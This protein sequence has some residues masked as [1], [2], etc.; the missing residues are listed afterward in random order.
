[1]RR[2]LLSLC[3]FCIAAFSYAQ[4][5]ERLSSYEQGLFGEQLH[6]SSSYKVMSQIQQYWKNQYDRLKTDKYEIVQC[7]TGESVLKVT[8]PS[9]YLFVDNNS[10]LQ[11]QAD[12]MLRPF[13]RFLRGQEAV[14]TVIIACYSDDNGSQNYLDFMTLN[15]A[16]SVREWLQK[17]GVSS[18]V[19]CYGM[20][21]KVPLN[22]NRNMEER[23]LNRRV[24]LYLVPNRSMVKLAK[25]NKLI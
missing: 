17:Q 4:Q 21:N 19:L 20:G 25:K 3:C 5:Y 1:M 13:L 18:K 8:I 2:V 22:E 7:G 23:E 15:R 12:G 10:A 6:L 16:Y 14:A 9:R 11:R 24:A